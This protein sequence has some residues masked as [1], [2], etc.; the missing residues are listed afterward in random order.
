LISKDCLGGQ[1]EYKKMEVFLTQHILL[2][3]SVDDNVTIK[4]ILLQQHK[5]EN[6]DKCWPRYNYSI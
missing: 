4:A 2:V 6:F 3:N 5:E 1:E